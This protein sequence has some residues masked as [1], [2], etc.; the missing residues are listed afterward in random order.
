MRT[1]ARLS[2]SLAPVA[3]LA[4]AG[5]ST[6][7]TEHA[8]HWSYSGETGPAHWG[9]MHPEWAAAH[10]GRAQ[11][12]I[13][14]SQR[15]AIE[16]KLPELRF[17]AAP[18]TVTPRDNGHT[19]Q[20]DC[21][22]ANTLTVGNDVFALKQFHF[23]APSEHTVDGKHY[24]VELHFVHADAAG[25][26]AVVGVMLSPSRG[27]NGVYEAVTRTLPSRGGQGAPVHFN[28]Y[29]LLPERM[30]YATYQG[31]LTTPPCTEGVR[32]I[33]LTNPARV[34]GEQVAA[35]TESYFGNARPVQPANGRLVFVQD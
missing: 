19:I 20:W 22:G 10:E 35:F 24:P 6:S 1:L 13:N 14:L 28:P 30:T 11:S 32:W 33:V 2:L 15:S 17:S 34:T 8:A 7:S 5:C 25:N 3:L 29:A 27:S 23:H 21:H 16:S 31:S 4:A 26:L 18:T 9:A 12:P